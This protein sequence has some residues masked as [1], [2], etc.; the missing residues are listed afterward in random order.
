MTVPDADTL[1]IY[2]AKV[3]RYAPYTRDNT[4]AVKAPFPLAPTVRSSMSSTSSRKI[5]PT[6][7]FSA[8]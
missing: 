7:R 1:E 3:H 8:T 4:T 2:S 6:I 5:A